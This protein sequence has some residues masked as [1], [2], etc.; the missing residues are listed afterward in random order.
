MSKSYL[1]KQMQ[2]LSRS[3]LV[4]AVEGRDGGYLLPAP[5]PRS[6][7]TTWSVR[8]MGRN[9]RSRCTEIRQQGPLPASS[10]ACKVPCGIAKVMATA[11]RAWRDSLRQV[12]LADLA[13]SVDDASPGAWTAVRGWL[14][15]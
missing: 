10:E 2:L 8:S 3:G 9:R 14:S 13:A 7:S 4:R 5:G 6:R 1:A 15:A 12:S 11:E